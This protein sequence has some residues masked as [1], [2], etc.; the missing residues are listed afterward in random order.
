MYYGHYLLCFDNE[1]NPLSNTFIQFQE[2]SKTTPEIDE[3]M[4][5]QNINMRNLSFYTNF[6]DSIHCTNKS[7]NRS[8][9]S[10]SLIIGQRRGGTSWLRHIL[11]QHSQII[12]LAEI[13]RIWYNTHC[14]QFRFLLD[15]ENKCDHQSMINTINSAY[16]N[17]IKEYFCMDNTQNNQ[18]RIVFIGKIQIEQL[19]LINMEMLVEYIFINNIN[20]IHFQRAA[21]IA[22]YL[23]YSFDEI[24]R[25]SNLN[26]NNFNDFVERNRS[27]TKNKKLSHKSIYL[28]PSLALDYVSKIE[29]K[30]RDFKSFIMKYNDD[31]NIINYISLYYEYL[32]DSVHSND[33]IYLQMIESFLEIESLRINSTKIT[34]FKREHPLP[35]YRKIENWNEIKSKLKSV[36]SISAIACEKLVS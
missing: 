32:M 1:C 15:E 13:L 11:M 36:K 21:V 27:L 16:L 25:I 17:G 6:T 2:I 23:S 24:E 29:Q 19:S 14:S 28:Q 20:I 30:H 5:I 10:L 34:E 22:S 12:D 31:K 4:L 7:I 3:S 8:L 35:C 33:I 9:I 26:N 18:K